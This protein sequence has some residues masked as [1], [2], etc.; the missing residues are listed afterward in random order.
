MSRSSNRVPDDVGSDH[1]RR[2]HRAHM[3]DLH[4]TAV[5]LGLA[6]VG[7]MGYS[8]IGILRRRLVYNSRGRRLEYNGWPAVQR[9]LAGVAFGLLFILVGLATYL[10]RS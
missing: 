9:G 8:L 1:D 3:N 5:L 4:V 6:G 10:E 2:F 7:M